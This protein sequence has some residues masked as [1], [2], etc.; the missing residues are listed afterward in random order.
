MTTIPGLGQGL[1]ATRCSLA[2]NHRQS[3]GPLVLLKMRAHDCEI[4]DEGVSDKRREH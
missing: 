4:L 2:R 3:R 1:E